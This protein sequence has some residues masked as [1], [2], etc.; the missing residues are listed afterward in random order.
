MLNLK[1]LLRECGH[2]Q[3]DLAAAVDVSP[4]TLA[5][6]INHGIWPKRPTRKALAERIRQRL[7]EYGASAAALATAFDAV[8]AASIQPV[9]QQEDEAMLLRKQQLHQNTRKHFNLFRDPFGEPTCAD[10][11]WANSPDVR[12]VR[13]ALGQVVT[14]ETFLAVIGES[15]AGKSTLRRDLIDRIRAAGHPVIVIEPY[16]LGLEDTLEKGKPLKALDI[17]GAIIRSIDPIARICRTAE[18]RFEQ[19]HRVLRDSRRSGNRHVLIIEEAHGLSVPTL[20]HLKRFF[21]LEDGFH[22]LLS[23]VLIGQQELAQ[24]LSEHKPE[25]REVVQRCEIVHLAP[26]DAQ[27]EDYLRHRFTRVGADFDALVD[28]SATDAIRARLV[29]P[30]RRDS[31]ASSLLYPLAVTNLLIASLNL[32]ADLGA[33]KVDGDVVRAVGGV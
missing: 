5:Q 14:S 10:D 20:K 32:A 2:T 13:A 6:L 33:P 25:V 31:E 8:S 7:R 30:A 11:V 18:A 15:G 21:E 3:R 23:I 4:A 12:Y 16:V 1:H 19:V 22:R 9:Q 28:A 29:T 24:K 17:A 27:L 26:L